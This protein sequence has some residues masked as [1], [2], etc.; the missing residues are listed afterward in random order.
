[1]IIMKKILLLG[2]VALIT[3]SLKA[4]NTVCFDVLP[5]PHSGISG[6]DV[7]TKYIDV[8]GVNIFGTAAVP[9]ND[10][11]HCAAVMAEYLDNDEDGLI[12]N[13]AVVD[14]MTIVNASMV[15]FGQD[16]SADQTSFFANYV[17]NWELQDL[18]ANETQP[19]GSSQVNGFD[20]TLE[21]VLHLI[22]HVG[23]ANEYPSIWGEYQGTS[24]AIAMDTARGGYYAT[25]PGTYPTAAWYH[26][27]DVTCDYS[28]MIAE[29]VYWSLTTLLGAQDYTGR[30]AEISNEWELCTIVDFQNM[31]TIM[32]NLLINP[33][34]LLA[35]ALPDG[36]YCPNAG[37]SKIKSPSSIYAYPNPFSTEL[38][39]HFS[40]LTASQ[41]TINDVRGKLI[42][43]SIIQPGLNI[44]D[45]SAVP[46][47]IYFLS[48]N[49]ESPIKIIRFH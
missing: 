46:G 49:N 19:S 3:L 15:M 17:G 22:T 33:N 35:T 30:C 29:Y 28:C 11:K 37:L 45:L 14:E 27:D 8:F 18:Y 36:N 10:I 40:G 32:N 21:E 9:D 20:A 23:Y 4:Q 25:I 6:L 5:N 13:Q 43:S 2:V 1:M 26:Y 47:G 34:Y 38:S 41:C 39:I 48:V 24:V 44:L 31:D 16:G 42:F 7:F 12:D